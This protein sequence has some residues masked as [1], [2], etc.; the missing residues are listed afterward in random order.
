MCLCK[1]Q[2]Q[3]SLPQSVLTQSFTPSVGTRRGA[4]NTAEEEEDAGDI[5]PERPAGTAVQRSPGS[6]SPG[7]A[8]SAGTLRQ[9]LLRAIVLAGLF[10]FSFRVGLS[11]LTMKGNLIFLLIR[12]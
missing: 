12:W 2:T 6:D 8:A 11:S 10:I 9:F 3:P 7:F 5:P 4:L 1:Q